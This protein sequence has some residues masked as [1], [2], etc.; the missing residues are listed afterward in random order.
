MPSKV[1]A[2]LIIVNL[3]LWT[4]VLIAACST[5]SSHESDHYIDEARNA[6]QADRID[7]ARALAELAIDEGRRKGEA[8]EILAEIYR[9]RA[10]QWIEEEEFLRA[11]KD[12]LDAAEHEPTASL[13]GQD[14]VDAITYGDAAGLPPEDLL[15]LTLLALQD[16]PGDSDLRR[17]AARRAEDLGDHDLAIEQYLWLFS[18]DPEDSRA[19]LRLGILFMDRERFNDAVSV[20]ERVYELEPDNVQAALNLAAGYTEIRHHNGAVEIYERLLESFPDHPAVLRH[21]ADLEEARG[22]HGRAQQLRQRAGD[23]SPGV[24]QR[25][26]RPLR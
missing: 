23:A 19:G 5:S 8:R 15:A 13:R 16:L 4:T 18:A 2:R 26:M 1:V 10:A 21:Y 25:E 24:E 17:N 12:Y 20:L 6:K 7:E 22:R 3:V 9:L 14:R 11:H